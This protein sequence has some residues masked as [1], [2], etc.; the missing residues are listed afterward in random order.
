MQTGIYGINSGLN[1]NHKFRSSALILPKDIK[2]KHKIRDSK[3][4][5]L[6]ASGE[7]NQATIARKFNL[8]QPRIN[9]ILKIN[10]R[11]ILDNADWEKIQRLGIIKSN[12]GKCSDPLNQKDLIELWRK[13]FEAENVTNNITQFLNITAQDASDVNNRLIGK[14]AL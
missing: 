2:T 9:T 12:I 14:N 5:N 1:T 3:I 13:E 6:Y 7:M 10:A 11:L 4:L 8:S